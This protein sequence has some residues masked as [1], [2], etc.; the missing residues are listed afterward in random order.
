MAGGVVHVQLHRPVA[1]AVGGVH[2]AGDGRGA[3]AVHGDPP[4]DGDGGGAHGRDVVVLVGGVGGV[5]GSLGGDVV[6]RLEARPQHDAVGQRVAGLHARG[7]AGGVGDKGVARAPGAVGE[8]GGDG[9]AEGGGAGDGAEEAQGGDVEQRGG[10][11]APGVAGGGGGVGR[12][13]ED[14]GGGG[15]EGGGDGLQR[16]H[17]A[18]AGAGV[19]GVGGHVGGGEKGAG[20]GLVN[21]AEPG[22][23]GV[24]VVHKGEAR[25][26]EGRVA[27]G[28]PHGLAGLAEEGVPAG[29]EDGVG[30]GARAARLAAGRLVGGDGAAGRVHLGLV[31]GRG[32]I[33]GV[34]GDRVLPGGAVG[35]QA[36]AARDHVVHVV[37]VGSLHVAAVAEGEVHG[38][39]LR[40]GRSELGGAT[41]QRVAL[42]GRAES[43]A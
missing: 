6:G 25:E 2:A 22:E 23:V 34:G 31:G 16:G 19:L 1:A 43:L 37:T 12:A 7:E 8:V 4:A 36:A 32:R 9:L 35:E 26:A 38:A 18:V 11:G 10:V 41:R 21:V 5:G 17:G 20:A 27:V 39:A 40:G 29:V 24:G 3:V 14:G 30:H 33:V 28:G 15:E 13:G 42:R